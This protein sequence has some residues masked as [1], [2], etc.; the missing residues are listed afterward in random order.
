MVSHN[1]SGGMNNSNMQLSNH[2]LLQNGIYQMQ[3]KTVG[4]GD[5]TPRRK[6]AITF[7]Q[8]RDQHRRRGTFYQS[9]MHKKSNK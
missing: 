8:M 7:A 4:G 9:E 5:I 6:M 1:S 2:V 3:Q